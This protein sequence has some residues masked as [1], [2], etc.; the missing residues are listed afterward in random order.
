MTPQHPV[1]RRA[2]LAG[3]AGLA[4]GPLLARAWAAAEE[5][6]AAQATLPM[7]EFGS[8]GR[9]LPRLGLGTAPV[10]TLAS[11]DEGVAVVNAAIECGVRYFDTAPSYSRGR[12]EERLGVA[13]RG[14]KREDYF[15]ATKT[16]ARD[17]DGARRE[18]EQSLKRLG[19]DYLDSIQIHAVAGD[20]ERLFGDNAVL[21]GLTRAHDEGLVR[22]IGITGHFNPKPLIEACRRHPFFHV[23]IPI[24]P[25]DTKRH[26]FTRQFLPFAIE[27]KVAV[28]AMKIYAD[29]RLLNRLSV[30]ECV[31]YA[32][33]QKGVDVIVPGC[34]TIG[35]VEEA[36]AA[37]M[38][39]EPL[40]PEVQQE[41]EERAG[42]HEGRSSEWYKDASE[43]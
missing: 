22:H 4:A 17:A 20:V 5:P 8:S 11:D 3:S 24:N 35:H 21:A 15:V 14:R 12:A 31:H 33:S 13:L 40:S 19:T 16:L 29:G 43:E 26:S 7:I 18:V 34:R 10:G 28:V 27:H 32:L 41:L 1:T 25:L 6:P 36:Y 30:D 38:S 23:L 42:P 37:A 39:F 9:M 2:F